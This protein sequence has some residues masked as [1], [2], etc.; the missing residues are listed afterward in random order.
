MHDWRRI[1][2]L[3]S[4]TCL[5]AGPALF[6]LGIL[7]RPAGSDDTGNQ[8]LAYVRG[9][10]TAVQVSDL[11]LIVAV[12]LLVPAFVGAMHVLRNRTPLL[13]YLGGGLATV[14]FVCLFGMITVDGVALE[15][16]RH[17]SAA[18]MGAVLDQAP[19]HDLLLWML[20]MVFVAG[21][22]VGT[23]LLG[24]ALF[25]ARFVPVWA[26]VAVAVSQP[27]HFVAHGID[28]KPLDVV[29]FALFAAGL[30]TLGV[31]LLRMRD[32]EWE[33]QPADA[34]RSAPQT[35]APKKQEAMA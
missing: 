8:L 17:G 32:A 7:V 24:I 28:S 5:A 13:G 21:H 14:G 1:R 19:N 27:L 31:R 35:A 12:L 20:T 3:F 34:G 33:A 6:F 11:M 18:G 9:N 22:I 29:A 10:G 16:A 30:A 4:G 2:R 23:T 26:A 15:M 25:R